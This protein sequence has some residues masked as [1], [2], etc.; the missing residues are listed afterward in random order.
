M[1]MV[2]HETVGVTDPIV[3]L[4]NLGQDIQKRLAISIILVD[5]FPPVP[6]GCHVVEGSGE[7]DA[8]GSGHAQS[9]ARFRKNAIMRELTPLVSQNAES[10]SL[11]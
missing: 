10:F 7:L 6:P 1:V 4:H 9:L 5:R 8:Q 2:C 11:F 3:A